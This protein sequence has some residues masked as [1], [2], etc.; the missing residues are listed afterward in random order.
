MTTDVSGRRKD[1]KPSARCCTALSCDDHV[2]SASG[3][4]LGYVL[5]EIAT[6]RSHLYDSDDAIILCCCKTIIASWH[7]AMAR[8]VSVERL[9]HNGSLVLIRYHL[10]I[11]YCDAATGT[12]E[13]LF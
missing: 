4:I 5:N 1:A 13:G 7:N 9:S 6:H 12:S 8:I 11:S 10:I 2:P 3:K